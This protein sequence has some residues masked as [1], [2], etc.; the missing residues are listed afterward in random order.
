MTIP[1]SVLMVRKAATLALALPEAGLVVYQTDWPPLLVSRRPWPAPDGE[2]WMRVCPFR[3]REQLGRRTEDARSLVGPSLGIEES[4]VHV[5]LVGSRATTVDAA[6]L[7]TSE[8][9]DDT[10]FLGFAVS[11]AV[12]IVDP[13]GCRPCLDPHR[14]AGSLRIGVDH[15]LGTQLVSWRYRTSDVEHATATR[16]AARETLL[17]ASVDELVLF[18]SAAP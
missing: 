1:L 17:T 5:D 6:G 15:D 12:S 13:A 2:V 16:H 10:S 18:S 4:D 7:V 9:V 11:S 14:T 8:R 3:F